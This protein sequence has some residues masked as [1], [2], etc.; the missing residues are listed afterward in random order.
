M[1]KN[2]KFMPLAVHCDTHSN[3]MELR[4]KIRPPYKASAS[5]V[6][7]YLIANCKKLPK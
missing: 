2:E 5:E 4:T 3:V 6:I 7:D 1:S